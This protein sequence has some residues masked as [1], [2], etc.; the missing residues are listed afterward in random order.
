MSANILLIILDSVRAKNTSLYDYANKTTPFL[1]EFSNYAT[2]YTQ[3]RSPSTWSLPSHT[4][5]FTGYDVAEHNIGS[6]NH[7][8]KPGHSVWEQLRDEFNYSTAVFSDNP[9]ITRTKYGLHRGFDDVISGLP[10][11]EYP[12]SDGGDPSRFKKN[13]SDEANS[14][15]DYLNYCIRHDNTIPTFL[16]GF[17]ALLS[18]NRTDILPPELSTKRRNTGGAYAKEFLRWENA[19]NG[20]WAVC[21]N[22]VDAHHPYLPRDQFDQWGGK[23][24]KDLHSELTDHRW[25]FHTGEKPW[26]QRQ[27]LESLYDGCILEADNAVRKI[28][29]TLENRESLNDTLV[30]VTSDH[31]E[32]FGEFSRVRPGHRLTG[33]E[34]GIHECQLH[35]PL[36]VKMPGQQNPV[37]IDELASLSRFPGVVRSEIS[38]NESTKN[39]VPDKPVVSSTDYDSKYEA[40]T[41]TFDEYIE[42]MDSS[43]FSGWAHA[44]YD[45][46]GERIMKYSEWE[47]FESSVQ[48]SNAQNSM[49]VGSSAHNEIDKHIGSL[50]NANIK[51]KE[52]GKANSQTRKRLQKL[53]YL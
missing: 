23:K 41:R 21:M 46:S 3:A 53:G 22:L 1:E 28:I 52:V 40:H 20:Q 13:L 50:S 39:F 51:T 36:I 27:A 15:V 24:L 35:V 43:A 38:T 45:D 8:L 42:R 12:F 19:T 16:N 49:K 26:W 5:I 4:S 25:D 17:S 34:S 44:V 11:K 30:V 9:F 29:E 2:T 10:S 31:G 33:N 48:I 47:E 32:G 18:S 6:R 7:Q 14:K 37:V